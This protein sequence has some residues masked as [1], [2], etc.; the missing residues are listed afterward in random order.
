[1]HFVLFG[2]PN[3]P[4]LLSIG[5]VTSQLYCQDDPVCVYIEKQKCDAD[6]NVR[7][8]CLSNGRHCG[9]F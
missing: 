4:I 7:A 6:L 3:T 1:M 2:Y 8:S 9:I 5:V